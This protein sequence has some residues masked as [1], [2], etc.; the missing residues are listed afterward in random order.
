M[1]CRRHTEN[2]F[3]LL[4]L[5]IVLV[6][7]AVLAAGVVPALM[8]AMNRTHLRSSAWQVASQLAF[9][10]AHAVSKQ[11]L[12]RVRFDPEELA[13]LA[14]VEQDP[15]EAPGEFAPLQ[16]PPMGRVALPENFVDVRMQTVSLTTPQS[17]EAVYFQPN[18]RSDGVEVLLESLD[19]VAFLVSVAHGAGQVR[20]EEGVL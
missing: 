4:E 6:I 9:A 18:G 17:T 15:E 7:V 8:T 10:R 1:R 12:C 11:L 3:T 5:A 16:T 14:E 20:V 19:G 13:F 2:G